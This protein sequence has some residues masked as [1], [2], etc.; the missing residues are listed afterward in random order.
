MNLRDGLPPKIERAGDSAFIEQVKAR[1]ASYL[2][3]LAAGSASSGAAPTLYGEAAAKKLYEAL[4]GR[5]VSMVSSSDIARLL[6]YHWLLTAEQLAE[7]RRID[8]ATMARAGQ[9]ANQRARRGR[10]A[11]VSTD[12][13]AAVASLFVRR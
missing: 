8:N 3:V 11:A 9:V 6:C 5:P 2:S 12:A 13:Q 10:K 1:M 4:I 7:L